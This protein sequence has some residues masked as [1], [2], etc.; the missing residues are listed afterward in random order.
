MVDESSP[1]EGREFRICVRKRFDHVDT[2][3]TMQA[4]CPV[5]TVSWLAK[6]HSVDDAPIIRFDSSKTNA[7]CRTKSGS[8]S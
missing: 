5:Q 1:G 8:V 7:R 3:H 4:S 6:C 2:Q